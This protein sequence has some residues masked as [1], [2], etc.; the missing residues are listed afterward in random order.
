MRHHYVAQH[1]CLA[2]HSKAKEELNAFHA[3]VTFGQESVHDQATM[4]K[5]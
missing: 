2:A 5:P 1:P 3:R 4:P